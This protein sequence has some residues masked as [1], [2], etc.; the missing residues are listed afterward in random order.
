MNNRISLVSAILLILT[1]I[2][3]A[4]D[5]AEYGNT[6]EQHETA[7]KFSYSAPPE[8][9]ENEV[10]YVY[11][12]PLDDDLQLQ[13][14]DICN[15]Y[16]VDKSLVFAM[17]YVESRYMVDKIGDNGNSYGLLQIQPR[18]WA[19]TMRAAGA[20]D[21]LNPIDNVK[22]CCAILTYL[23]DMYGDTTAVLQAYNTGK[24]N[25]SNGYAQKVYEAREGLEVRAYADGGCN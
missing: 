4:A 18:W 19:D 9:L 23:Y 17:M 8:E 11:N 24:P 25:S 7:D 10:K 13:I 12:V 6:T 16:E 5:K 15:E 22:T 1:I 21:L 14:F 3:V 20:T 2:L